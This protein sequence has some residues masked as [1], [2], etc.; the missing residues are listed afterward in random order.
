MFVKSYHKNKLCSEVYIQYSV[1]ISN[2]S[3]ISW[4]YQ[5]SAEKCQMEMIKEEYLMKQA[6]QVSTVSGRNIK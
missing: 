6:I 3:N 1:W 4:Q 2:I 5:F